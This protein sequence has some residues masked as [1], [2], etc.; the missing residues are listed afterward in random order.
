VT[1]STTQETKKDWYLVA[2]NPWYRT[3]YNPKTKETKH[4]R[5]K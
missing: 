4:E 1:N 3:L 5:Y 2:I